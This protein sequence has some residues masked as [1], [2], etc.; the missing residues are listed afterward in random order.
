[1]G[2]K[3]RLLMCI[4]LFIVHESAFSSEYIYQDLISGAEYKL[5][6]DN[7]VGGCILSED[8]FTRAVDHECSTFYNSD[9]LSLKLIR[10][11]SFKVSK[12]SL[13]EYDRLE[14]NNEFKEK[15]AVDVWYKQKYYI[16]DDEKLIIIDKGRDLKIFNALF[17]DVYRITYKR[18]N[19]LEHGGVLLFSRYSGVIAFAK[20]VDI[21]QV[22]PFQFLIGTCGYGGECNEGATK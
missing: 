1:M 16:D 3:Q 21:N 19:T 6:V 9:T 22:L 10:F 7:E 12:K 8:G 15:M 13:D 5:S 4:V 11:S 17:K 2:K 20:S 18:K 14:K